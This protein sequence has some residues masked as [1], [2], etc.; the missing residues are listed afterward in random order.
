MRVAVAALALLCALPAL[1]QTSPPAGFSRLG[2]ALIVGVH[3]TPEPGVGYPLAEWSSLFR[4]HGHGTIVGLLT[5]S[6]AGLGIGH[7]FTDYQSPDGEIV[8]F[9]IGPSFLVPFDGDGLSSG[10]AGL[11]VVVSLHPQKT[12]GERPMKK[13]QLVLNRETLRTLQNL[14]LRE[15][16]GNGTK[17]EL[18]SNYQDGYCVVC[19]HGCSGE[20]V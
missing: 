4:N 10:R 15:A 20:P 18:S 8:S 14:S 13:K 11:F 5:K 1:A 17:I 6:A 2:G 7:R 19:S 3:G 9:T 12:E 16:G